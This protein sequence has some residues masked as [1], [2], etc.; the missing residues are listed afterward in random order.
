MVARMMVAVM[1]VM[2]RAII[3]IS[4][5]FV[6]SIIS[7]LLVP[8]KKVGCNRP[9][10]CSQC[11]VVSHLVTQESSCS[12]SQRRFAKTAFSFYTFI[13][14]FGSWRK[15]CVGIV[16]STAIRGGITTSWLMIRRV[17]A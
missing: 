9:T 15:W 1:A 5:A 14:A 17:A 6:V 4:Q 2:R 13:G 7:L 12:G 16:G 8:A 10:N 11:P 3:S